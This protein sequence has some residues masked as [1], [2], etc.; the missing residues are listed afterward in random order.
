MNLG[1]P[2]LVLL[3]RVMAELMAVRVLAWERVMAELMAVRVL[4]RV[5]FFMAVRVLFCLSR[6]MEKATACVP[7]RNSVS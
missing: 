4:V 2:G 7:D 5:L 3:E 6:M 1:V